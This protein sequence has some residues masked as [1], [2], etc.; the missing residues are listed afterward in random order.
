MTDEGRDAPPISFVGAAA[1][2]DAPSFIRRTGEA[3]PSRRKARDGAN[4]K[5]YRPSS[6]PAW[7]GP[8]SPRGRL[9]LEGPTHPYTGEGFFSVPA[10][11]FVDSYRSIIA[12]RRAG[13]A[14]PLQ[15]RTG[16][17]LKN[18]RQPIS[19]LALVFFVCFQILGGCRRFPAIFFLRFRG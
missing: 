9:P 3:Q 4:H 5:R 13:R 19:R 7:A 17:F 12:T 14:P 6:G 11:F 1:C 16:L 8:P 10:G 2:S 18:Q 15:G